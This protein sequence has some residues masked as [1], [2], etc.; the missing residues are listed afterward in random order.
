MIFENYLHALGRII[1][2]LILLINKKN[3]RRWFHFIN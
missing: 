1:G 2:V 3:W